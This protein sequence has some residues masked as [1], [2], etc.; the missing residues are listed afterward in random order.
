MLL[1]LQTI[2]NVLLL[3]NSVSCSVLSF[4]ASKRSDK[5]NPTTTTN[6]P[7]TYRSIA[8]TFLWKW[9]SGNLN[10]FELFCFP[11]NLNQICELSL[12]QWRARFAWNSWYWAFVVQKSCLILEAF[13]FQILACFLRNQINLSLIF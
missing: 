4:S 12:G 7:F 13:L 9:D 1:L 6:F 5:S 11:L 10:L 2:V 8:E 3:T